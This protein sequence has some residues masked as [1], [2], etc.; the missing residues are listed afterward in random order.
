MNL[1]EI[2]A[3]WEKDCKIDQTNLGRS[4]GL[5]PE[6]HSK[7]LKA[8]T[9]HKLSLRKA[10]SDLIRM[11]KQKGRY[12]R[13]EMSKEELADYGWEQFLNRTPLK[14]EMEE[15][16]QSDDDIIRLVDKVDYLQTVVYTLEQIMRS[17]NSRTWDVKNAIEW[18]KFTNGV[19]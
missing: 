12:Y 19:F 7:Y 5:I 13:G 1:Q 17:I 8:L 14:N 3:E 4:A 6:L 16:L 10:Q 18:Q 11:R 9:H 2:Q 15:V